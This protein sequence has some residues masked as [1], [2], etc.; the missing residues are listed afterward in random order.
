[1]TV[2]A[3]C[4]GGAFDEH[5]VLWD[6]LAQAW[7]L[8]AQERAYID[9]QQGATCTACGSN[10]RSSALARAICSAVG[11]GKTLQQIVASPVGACLAVLEIN[12]AGHLHPWLA[13]L[14][15]HQF[16]GYPAVDMRA[17]PYA[18]AQF[19]LVVHSDTLE[20]VPDPV[21]ALSEC[22][23][24]LKPSGALCFTIPMIVGWLTRDCADRPPSYHGAPGDNLEDYRV[25][26]EFGADA[27][28]WC[29][30]A[31]FD[32]VTI[33]T[34]EFPAAQAFTAWKTRSA[35]MV[36]GRELRRLQAENDILRAAHSPAGSAAIETAMDL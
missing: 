30:R 31:G 9:R 27:W 35:P 15:H 10:L 13:Q 22:R 36:L 34:V 17:M 11:S 23:R 26:T 7:E 25:V 24:V 28:S 33:A 14:P 5:A 4:G 16:A 8:S 20:H 3:V 12:D 32:N 29:I 21:L 2:C 6:E 19:D 1:V 18:D